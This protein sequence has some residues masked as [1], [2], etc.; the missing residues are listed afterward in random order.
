MAYTNLLGPFGFELRWVFQEKVCFLE[1][2]SVKQALLL[3]TVF[4]H[5]YGYSISYQD[6]KTGVTDTVVHCIP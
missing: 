2:S 4:L 3:R 6:P 1:K 5:I